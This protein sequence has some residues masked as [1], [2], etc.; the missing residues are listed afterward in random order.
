MTDRR[1]PWRVAAIGTAVLSLRPLAVTP[2]RPP[3][4]RPPGRRGTIGGSLG[5]GVRGGRVSGRIGRRVRRRFGQRIGRGRRVRAGHQ[6]V[7]ARSA[8]A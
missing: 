4:H 6:A 8:A 5:G 3:R 2:A 1:L 7:P